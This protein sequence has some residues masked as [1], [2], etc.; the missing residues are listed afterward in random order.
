MDLSEIME[1]Y[2]YYQK[3]MK[4][5]PFNS[6]TM[7]RDYEKLFVSMYNDKDKILEERTN[8]LEN[9]TTSYLSFET[10]KKIKKIK[11]IVRQYI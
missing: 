11:K 8:N 4:S 3:Q 5:Y 7:C 9:F 2:D 10:S 6:E 1:N